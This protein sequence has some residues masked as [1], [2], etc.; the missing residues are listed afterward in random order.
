AADG[1]PLRAFDHEG[2]VGS[3]LF[4]PN[5]QYLVIGGRNCSCGVDVLS[6]ADG[7]R[8]SWVTTARMVG[9]GFSPDGTW[10]LTASQNAWVKCCAGAPGLSVWAFP[11]ATK[12]YDL[13][14]AYPPYSATAAVLS[15]DGELVAAQEDALV[16]RQVS[17]GTVVWSQTADELPIGFDADAQTLVT[18]SDNSLIY[19]RASDGELVRTVNDDSPFIA[20]AFSSDR[21]LLASCHA[22]GTIK[23]WR[24]ADGTLLRIYTNTAASCVAF[25]PDSGRIAWG[26]EDGSIAVAS[27]PY[28][29]GG[30]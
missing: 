18:M 10:L 9:I 11:D 17:D 16:L 13:V 24:T 30:Q 20:T 28:G 22:D 5:G 26:R 6:L 12:L 15:P 8:V 14:D 21:A 19:R 1:T 27:I 23:L 3:L 29:P 4:S 25:S 2:E 7:L